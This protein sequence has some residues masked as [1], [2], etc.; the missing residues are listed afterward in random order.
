LVFCLTE[1]CIISL[2]LTI[3]ETFTKLRYH[4]NFVKGW[5]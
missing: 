5:V 1:L 4:F 2:A 3:N